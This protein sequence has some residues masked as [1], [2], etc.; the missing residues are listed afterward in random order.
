M[1]KPELEQYREE[2]KDHIRQEEDVLSY[3]LFPQVALKFFEAREAAEAKQAAPEVA[4]AAAQP[5]D[6]VQVLY[7]EDLSV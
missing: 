1:L 4:P 3:A 6:A 7:V 2:I 5:A